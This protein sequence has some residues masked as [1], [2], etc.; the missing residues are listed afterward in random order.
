[1][2]GPLALPDALQDLILSKGAG[3]PFFIEEVV[4]ALVD[5]GALRQ[6]PLGAWQVEQNVAAI[7]LP[8]TIHGVIISR[9]DRL[10]QVERQVLQVAAVM[11]RVFSRHG[12]LRRGS[13]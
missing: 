2:L 8:D 1:M 9:V 12:T 5:S 11:G 7:A 13:K 6:E 10:P 4:R 3:N